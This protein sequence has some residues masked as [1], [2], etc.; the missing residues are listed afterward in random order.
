M[1]ILFI[2]ITVQSLIMINMAFGVES[3]INRVAM[4]YGAKNPIIS[5]WNGYYEVNNKYMTTYIGD[6]E[7][8]EVM[9]TVCHEYCHHLTNTDEREH[10]CGS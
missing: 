3:K 5:N 8:F 10:F 1:T 7:G 6:R 2:I 9:T 4:R